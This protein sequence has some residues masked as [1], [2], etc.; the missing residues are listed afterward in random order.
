MSLITSSIICYA[1]GTRKITLFFSDI[2]EIS[3]ETGSGKITDAH[4]NR[5]ILSYAEEEK[6]NQTIRVFPRYYVFEIVFLI[7][8]IANLKESS[9][10][11]YEDTR[12]PGQ[13]NL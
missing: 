1:V 2:H 11:H 10:H 13:G 4:L 7:L 5:K 6:G 8:A 3:K 12:I 9:N